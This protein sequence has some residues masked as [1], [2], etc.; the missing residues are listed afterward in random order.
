MSGDEL[1]EAPKRNNDLLGAGVTPD[2]KRRLSELADKGP[3]HAVAAAEARFPRDHF[4]RMPGVFQHQSGH[5]DA[6]ILYCFGGGLAGLVLK[7]ATEL[8]WAEMHG[9]GEPLDSQRRAEIAPRIFQRLLNAVG[10]RLKL[11]Q[12]RM[13]GLTAAAAVVKDQVF[14]HQSGQLDR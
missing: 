8:T 2:F 13:L 7:R 9:F 4:D 11:K 5:L 1:H 6:Q 12:R 14:G 3:A 10:L